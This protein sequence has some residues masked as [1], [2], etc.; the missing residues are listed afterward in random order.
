VV[1]DDKAKYVFVGEGRRI[2]GK[3]LKEAQKKMEPVKLTDPNQ[4][5]VTS[6]DIWGA[7]PWKKRV[8][9]GVRSEAPYGFKALVREKK[10]IAP[11]F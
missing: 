6:V 4:E 9:G 5:K 3:D 10:I 11:K 8:V 7:E 2:D 1:K